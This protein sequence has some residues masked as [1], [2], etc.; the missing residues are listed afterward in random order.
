MA[1]EAEQQE[2]QK[3]IAENNVEGVY[4]GWNAS[5]IEFAARGCYALSNYR[6]CHWRTVCYLR[7]NDA[8]DAYDDRQFVGVRGAL[9]E[10][11]WCEGDYAYGIERVRSGQGAF[12]HHGRR[13]FPPSLMP[14]EPAQA[15]TDP[16]PEL[17]IIERLCIE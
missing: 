3:R 12:E 16:K 1:L 14:H 17:E 6:S 8:E 7:S 10:K 4:G 15:Q 9:Q 11:A 2:L 5:A 13:L